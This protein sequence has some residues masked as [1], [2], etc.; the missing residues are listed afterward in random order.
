[1]DIFPGFTQEEDADAV[2]GVCPAFIAT[3][4]QEQEVDAGEGRDDPAE[5]EDQ[6]NPP[7]AAGLV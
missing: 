1:M 7:V 2:E 6:V 5:E 4:G 3:R